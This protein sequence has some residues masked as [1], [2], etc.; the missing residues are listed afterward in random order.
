MNDPAGEEFALSIEPRATGGTPLIFAFAGNDLVVAD[1]ALPS[2]AALGLDASLDG[3][4]CIGKRGRSTCYALALRD[5]Q[6][7][8]GLRSIGLRAV[9]GELGPEAFAMAS[10]AAQLL[11]WDREH[12]FCG[13]CG[14]PTER[15]PG[16]PARICPACDLHAYPRISPAIMV[17]ITRGREV[18]L[19]RN[20]RNT[21]GMFSALAG[22][23][24]AGETLEETIVREVR[25]EVG[26]SVTG[27]RYFGSQSWPFPHS[28][29]IAFTAAYVSGEVTPDGI[30]IEEA[31]FFDVDELP[32]LPPAGL[33]IAS[34]LINAVTAQLRTPSVIPSGAPH[35][36]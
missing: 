9:F 35:G 11:R 19:A 5:P 12:R 27:I 20:K 30:E 13:A 32:Q 22:F 16:E 34:R 17:L 1:D 6:A 3:A 25:E 31:R 10:R 29:M 15:A 8:P 14:T 21:T 23:V 18:L 2:L 28:L 24:E 36:A 26:V 33:S 7:P 4:I